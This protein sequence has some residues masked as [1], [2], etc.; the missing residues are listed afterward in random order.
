[1]GGGEARAPCLRPAVP[2]LA[3]R[4]SPARTPFSEEPIATL[5]RR[6]RSGQD[7]RQRPLVRPSRASRR[8]G[9]VLGCPPLAAGVTGDVGRRTR[10][11]PLEARGFRDVGPGGGGS[12]SQPS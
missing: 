4:E 1:R 7:P 5:R 12:F 6:V 9:V 8:R 3:I 2:R 11:G 10:G